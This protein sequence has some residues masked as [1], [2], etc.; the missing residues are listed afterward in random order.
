[1][2]GAVRYL[3]SMSPIKMVVSGETVEIDI[4]RRNIRGLIVV[5]ELFNDEYSAYSPPILELSQETQM[6]CITLDYPE[7]V[8]YATRLS[9][10]ESFFQAFDRVFS[11]GI[12]TGMFP[13]LRLW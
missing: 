11:H 4:G 13:R 9:G 5:K 1:M 8:S 3:K 10:Q 2:K 12:E 6:P 7:L